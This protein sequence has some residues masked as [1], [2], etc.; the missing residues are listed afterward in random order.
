MK[1]IV[2]SVRSNLA[3]R[4]AV[5][6]FLTAS[7]FISVL[8]AVNYHF[9]SNQMIKAYRMK[10][11]TI[12]SYLDSSIRNYDDFRDSNG[13]FTMFQKS[14]WLDTDLLNVSLYR[15]EG[16]NAI[17]VV[18]SQGVIKGNIG[19]AQHLL[20][21][22]ENRII[23]NELH[24][25][26]GD[27]IRVFTPIHIARR[28]VG[29]FQ[30]DITLEN[31]YRVQR[32]ML[33]AMITANLLLVLLITGILFLYLRRHVIKPLYLLS[34]AA[35]KI[36][37][38]DLDTQVSI[39]SAD[40][41]GQL[42]Q[43]FN[44]MAQNLA[45]QHD[46]LKQSQKMD[47]IGQ[48]TG[49]IAHDFN[50]ILGV[51]IGNLE[52]LKYEISDN[53][54]ALKRVVT[55]DEVTQRA[56]DLV[57]QLL[58]FSRL[59]ATDVVVSNINRL[60]LNMDIL[61]KRS[62]TPEVEVE[63]KLADSLWSTG[64]NRG[65]FQDS[66]LNMILNARDAMPNGGLLTIETSNCTLDAVYWSLN[67]DLVVDEYVKLSVSDTGIGITSEQQDKIYEPFYTTKEVG[68]GAGLGLSMVFGFITR[69]KGH[70]DVE[71]EP[72]SGTTFHLYLP[73]AA[74]QAITDNIVE[75]K[76]EALPRGSE[77]ILV[78][79][80]EQELLDLAK[81]SLETLGYSVLTAN[82]GKEALKRLAEHSDISLLFSDVI[83]P[84]GMSGYE[85]ALT[86]HELY[87]SLKILVTS[88]FT[89]KREGF[90][91][92]KTKYYS[93]LASGL[94]NKPYYKSD[95]ATAVRRVLDEEVTS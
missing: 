42:G 79:D 35:G 73:R 50:N 67:P 26:D 60:I 8:L 92:G 57:R 49:G 15:A 11:K 46:Q 25:E 32:N 4:T 88:G 17:G 87:P 29:S 94:L 74:E 27:L 30:F 39:Q 10:A 28:Q 52:L 90:V 37:G 24:N 13:I 58:G 43:D 54:E 66:L 78:V 23:M 95:L 69:S 76:T 7:V 65:D 38:G 86:A 71:S 62:I 84:D 1:R 2:E 5:I 19:D 20:A 3:I 12:G 91:D 47:A 14:I 72:G 70:I 45:R 59:Q 21:F 89:K 81:E 22:N 34:D 6:G 68:K 80:D 85:L 82:S 9:V 55:I 56:V 16:G 18:S 64:I 51:I 63:L 83:M 40:E 61:I 53:D 75:Q 31:L 77:T 41:F 36:A 48:L 44:N 93:R 33:L